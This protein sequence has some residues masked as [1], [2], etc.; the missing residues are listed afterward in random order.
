MRAG[1][2]RHRLTI[3]ELVGSQNSYGEVVQTWSDVATIWGSIEP[4]RGKEYIEAA[5]ARASVDHRIRVRYRSDITPGKRIEYGSRTFEIV[6]V[7]DV[8]EKHKEMELMC[9]ELVDE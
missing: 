4:L 5:T 6:S 9:K 8:L 7:I 2:L 1:W 3:Q